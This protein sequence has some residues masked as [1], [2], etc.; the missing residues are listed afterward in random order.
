M[1][2]LTVLFAFLTFLGFQVLQA[3]AQEISGTVISS[4]DEL[5][6]PGASVL[7]K[8]TTIGTITDIDGNYSLEV[9]A[10]ANI[11]VYSFVGM[12]SQEISIDGR[13]TIDVVLES[14]I[15]GLDEVIVT[16]VG[17]RRQEKTLGYGVQSVNAEDLSTSNNSDIVNALSGKTAGVQ[18]TSSSGSAGAATYIT[19]RGAASVTG[20]NQP[21]FVVDGMPIISGGGSSGVGGVG[22]SS[23]TIDMNPDDIAS[24]TVLK[25]GAA[26]ALYGLR[27]ANGAIIIST[28]TGKSRK[29]KTKI[30]LHSSVGFE[31]VSQL[32]PIQTTFV[33]GNNGV[34]L[35]GFS[36]SWGPNADTLQYDTTTNPEYK[37]DENGMIVGQS[38]PNANGIP[39][40]MYDNPSNFF[41]TG[42]TTNNR[43]SVS[44]GNE[45]GDYFLSI[46]NM[47]QTGVVPNNKYGRTSVRF[48]ASSKLADNVTI[49]TNMAYSNS[50][51]NQIQKGSN[52]SGVMLGLVRTPPSFD[53]SA[54]YE[55]ADGTQRNY[56][57]G[58]G[59]DNPFW[60]A[61]NNYFDENVNRFTGNM[62]LNVRFTD[63]FNLSYNGGVDWY[64]RGYQNVIAVYSRDRPSGYVHEY[65]NLSYIFNSDLLLNFE[66]NIGNDLDFKFTLGNNLYST[67]SK[68]VNGD[69]TGLSIERFYQLS[70]TSNNTTWSGVHNYRTA[71]VF[72]D[73]QVGFRDM[74]FLG[75]TGRTDWSTTMPEENRSAFYPSTSLGF[76]FT[77][78]PGLKGNN[79]LPFGKIRGSWAKTA[80]I[81]SAYNTSNY[82]YSAGTGDGWTTGVNFPYMN[83]TGFSVGSGLG[84]PDLKHETMISWEVGMDLRFLENR[85][86][87]DF[88]YFQN[89]NYDLLLSVP[90]ARSTGFS[91]IY[92]NAAEIETKGLEIT[93]S[94]SVL[95]LSDFKWDVLANYTKMTNIVT[96]LAEGV[97]SL[98]LGGFVVPQVRAVAGEEYRSIYGF[99]W[100]RD[101]Q[102]QML[103]NDDPTDSHPDGYPMPD[104]RKMV[105]IGNVN[106]DWTANITNTFSYKGVR[107]SFLFDIKSGG[108]L[109][110]G[111]GF[112]M[113]YFGT[114]KRTEN[115]EVVYSDEG[116]IDFDKTPEENIVV[117]D[118]VMGH[119][120]AEGNPVSSGVDN[121]RPVVL[122][123]NW[124]EG[125]GS[126]F[127][128]G[129]SVAAM[130]PSDWVRLREL[131]LSY[132]I[133]IKKVIQ[134]AQIY[135][136]GR[137][138]WL[139][140][141]YTGIDPETNLQGASNGQGMDYFNMPGTKSYMFGLKLTF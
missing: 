54:G 10:D 1:K 125:Y 44:S 95:N 110:N 30:E 139:S 113:N 74:I 40:K 101:S 116:T 55:F 6:V 98:F 119:V 130:E 62:R 47:D 14:D 48:N 102:G 31:N 45:Y 103:I 22:T 123:E 94:A 92:M 34:W 137:N 141:P 15:F 80:N 21:L 19:I 128:G 70:N 13:A 69:A 16:A 42:I 86:G 118:G 91:S 106:P 59:Y 20:N 85:F 24:V 32:P 84:N 136:T 90:I 35:G 2:K 78:L 36:R 12:K 60:T 114:T 97:P 99:D 50:R 93:L 133:P 71:A 64:N 63:W 107:L 25:G 122:D 77:E 88:S 28:K 58:G 126:N 49:G 66:K 17:I 115:R 112:A 29:Q 100:Y 132:D 8:G 39:V 131:T 75:A 7:V 79:I 52:T 27:A 72:G 129:P 76:V 23:R 57:N 73:L 4:E 108:M 111:T 11:L 134:K 61:N 117:F 104:E 127:G 67:Y 109:Y 140:T 120:D 41:Q 105:P 87:L 96:K 68:S 9:P 89:L 33:Q 81:A 124:F 83:Q 38:D 46:G 65:S 53:N 3:Q 37:W 121:V 5:G 26:T 18:I 138:L 56:R 135:F 51:A 82:F 43:I